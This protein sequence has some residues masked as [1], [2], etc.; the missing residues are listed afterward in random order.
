MVVEDGFGDIQPQAAAAAV[1][2]P[3]FVHPIEGSEDTLQIFLSNVDAGILH[4]K[5]LV[6]LCDSNHSPRWRICHGISDHIG[7][8][9][10]H[11]P[12]VAVFSPGLSLAPKVFS[13]ARDTFMVHYE[14]GVGD[15]V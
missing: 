11:K 12:P 4:G 9:F 7:E 1:P 6:L 15:K 5:H 14:G 10:L 8:H 2:V 13:F 3:G